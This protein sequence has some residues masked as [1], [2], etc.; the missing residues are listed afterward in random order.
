M[1]KT[2]AEKI[3]AKCAGQK[4]VTA[5]EIIIGKVD[6]AMLDDTLGP[7]YVDAGLKRLGADIWDRSK[8]VLICDHYTPP[9]SI[10]QA[11]VVAFN[12]KWS[13]EY[14]IQNY[15]EE[16]GPCHQILAENG[17]DLP[18]TLLVGVDSHTV[19]AGA[20]GCFGTGIGSTE[21]VGVLATGE[22]WLM[23]PESMKI[24]WTGQLPRRVMAKDIFLRTIKDVKHAGATYQ[25]MEFCGSTIR[26]LPMDERMCISNMAVEAGAKA[27]LIACDDVTRQYLQQVGNRKAYEVFESDADAVYSQKLEYQATELIPQ[28]ACP[29]A[30]DNVCDVTAVAGIP[31]Q[32]SYI[33]SCTGGRMTDLLMAAEILKGKKLTR[34][35]KLLVSPSSKTIWEEAARTGIL[36]ILSEA[37]ATILAPTCGAC[38]GYHSGL[39]ADGET[40]VSTTNRNFKGR[41]GSRQADIYLASAATA[42]ASALAG[43]ITDPREI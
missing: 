17:F 35:C 36:N 12:R 21:M 31:I 23:V 1:G 9:G 4:N 22:I 37:G 41:M 15:F 5:G 10:A 14:E 34:D 16:C 2:L 32:R 11:N 29:H 24:T 28:L 25:A 33:G 6:C 7:P 20:F 3:L 30:V 18:G 40:C 26:A 42:A 39:L 19:T 8:V 38:V 43:K 27:G 13:K